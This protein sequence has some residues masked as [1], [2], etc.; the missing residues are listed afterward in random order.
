MTQQRT[1]LA[2][3]MCLA[4]AVVG[5]ALATT[6]T[7]AATPAHQTLRAATAGYLHGGYVLTDGTC[8]KHTVSVNALV[9]AST[10]SPGGHSNFGLCYIK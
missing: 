5:A 10:N 1:V 4:S 2:A 8:P 9:R 3:S 6:A 7:S